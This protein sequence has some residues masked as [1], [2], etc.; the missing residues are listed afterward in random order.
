M[1]PDILGNPLYVHSF[2][3]SRLN[4]LLEI[5]VITSK[6]MWSIFFFENVTEFKNK[7][8]YVSQLFSFLVNLFDKHWGLYCLKLQTEQGLMV[9]TVT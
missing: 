9:F 3:D 1:F 8:T 2:S 4:P 7:F 6:N 5:K